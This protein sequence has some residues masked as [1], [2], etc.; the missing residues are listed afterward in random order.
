MGAEDKPGVRSTK[1]ASPGD[2]SGL[3][4]ALTSAIVTHTCCRV[5]L[6]EGGSLI[7]V[8]IVPLTVGGG[9]TPPP[10]PPPPHPS[11]TAKADMSRA[12]GKTFVKRAIVAAPPPP[13]CFVGTGA[14]LLCK[15]ISGGLGLYSPGTQP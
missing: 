13:E 9:M 10:P 12:T 14:L 5:A 11:I 6:H 4:L 1:P 7:A 2:A 15:A 3:I 8:V